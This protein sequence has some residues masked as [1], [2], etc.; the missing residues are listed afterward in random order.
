MKFSACKEHWIESLLFFLCLC[1]TNDDLT[2]CTKCLPTF[3]LP[4]MQLFVEHKFADPKLLDREDLSGHM[5]MLL[6]TINVI[7]D[8]KEDVLETPPR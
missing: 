2:G 6:G 5:A 1:L 4:F 3:V 8:V 7:R